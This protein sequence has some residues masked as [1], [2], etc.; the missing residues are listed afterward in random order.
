[1]TPFLTGPSEKPKEQVQN[2]PQGV[3]EAEHLHL[4]LDFPWTFQQ[5]PRG[6]ATAPLLSRPAPRGHHLLPLMELGKNG[7]PDAW[8][9]V[10]TAG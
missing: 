6:S 3:Q 8:W 2:L 9:A 4:C 1:M 7:H 5:M 10:S